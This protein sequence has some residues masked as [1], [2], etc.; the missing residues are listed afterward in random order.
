VFVINASLWEIA[1]KQSIGKLNLT[2][3][4][5]ELFYF[6]KQK[7]FEILE[8]DINDLETLQTLPFYHQDPFDRIIVSQAKTKNLEIITNDSMVLKYFG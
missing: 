6:L 4:L 3:S 8:Y 1:I 7:G 2:V 5:P